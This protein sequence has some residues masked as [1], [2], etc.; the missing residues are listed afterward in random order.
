MRCAANEHMPAC[1]IFNAI[2]FALHALCLIYLIIL[3]SCTL[4]LQVQ[5]SCKISRRQNEY[6][7]LLRKSSLIL[8]TFRI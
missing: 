6:Q 7:K 1:M 8:N 5:I 4:D 3:V 2:V